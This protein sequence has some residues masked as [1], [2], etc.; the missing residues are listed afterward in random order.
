M[1]SDAESSRVEF[2]LPVSSPIVEKFG[3]GDVLVGVPRS[4]GAGEVSLLAFPGF[5]PSEVA[6]FLLLALPPRQR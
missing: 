4:I 1:V 6:S 2:I 3:G 5:F